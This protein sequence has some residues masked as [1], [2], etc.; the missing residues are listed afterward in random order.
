MAASIQGNQQTPPPEAGR[1]VFTDPRLETEDYARAK[2]QLLES[3]VERIDFRFLETLTKDA[4]RQRVRGIIESFIHNEV[5]FPLTAQQQGLLKEQVLDDLLGFGPLE[6]LLADPDV[7]DIMINGCHSVYIERQ[8]KIHLSDVKFSSEKHLLNV[9]QK[10]VS[11]VGRRIDEASPMVDARMPDGSRFNAIIPPLA[12]EGCL[13]SIRKF[14]KQKMS[15]HEYAQRGS[16]SEEMVRFLEICGHIRLNILISGG[17]GSGKTTLLNA[18]SGH[19]DPGERVITIEDTA[20]LHLHQPHVLRLETRPPNIEGHGEVNQRQLV[21][22]ALRMRPDRIILGEIRGD[23]VIDVLAAMN[24]G[25]DGSMATIHANNPKDAILRLENLIG[26][27]G[28]SLST[29]SVRAQIA[30]ALHLI[31]QVARM[32]DGCR[33][34]IQMDEVVASSEAGLVTHPL[35]GYKPGPMTEDGKLKGYFYTTGVTPGFLSQAEYFG[36]AEE[37]MACLQSARLLQE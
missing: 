30:S 12:L 18:L 29:H 23:E 8:G 28:A 21:K 5:R 15:L 37:M 1:V 2:L 36:R 34:I 3:L 7:S 35:F 17:T 25:H 27:S 31:I 33:R 26:L 6:P 24:T 20:E 10:I 32:R 14:K 4:K 13:V 19:I 16:A 22:N 9:I 11:L